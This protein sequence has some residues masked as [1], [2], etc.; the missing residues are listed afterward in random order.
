MRAGA[1]ISYC[2][3][4]TVKGKRTF[5][6][7]T[8]IAMAAIVLCFMLTLGL[9]YILGGEGFISAINQSEP[10]EKCY[11]LCVGAYEDISLARGAAELAASQGGAGYVIVGELNEVVLAA[12]RNEEDARKVL[13]AGGV[14]ASAYLKEVAV[15]EMPVKWARK[16]VRSSVEA[17]L[18]YFGTVFDCFY[19]TANLLAQDRLTLQ[20]ARTRVTVCTAEVNEL[21]ADYLEAV[22]EEEDQ[23]HTEIKLALVTALALLDNAELSGYTATELSAASSMRYQLVQLVICREALLAA[24]Q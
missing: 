12:Y 16:E 8:A 18:G 4:A 19:E 22:R 20:D 6:R 24:L 10:S 21:R 3:R 2:M 9:V 15:G 23:R 17:A 14:G 1:R 13:D 11:L 7:Q 5:D